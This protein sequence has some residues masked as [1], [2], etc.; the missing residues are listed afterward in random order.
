MRCEAWWP[1]L[2]IPASFWADGK[3]SIVILNCAEYA[4]STAN[5]R[6]LI[7]QYFISNGEYDLKVI[8]GALCA[9][10]TG[11]AALNQSRGTVSTGSKQVRAFP[12][13]GP[14]PGPVRG[15]GP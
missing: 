4:L 5:A 7:L 1:V 11:A 10:G 2:D 3:G 12:E 13:K 8:N 14:L 6:D 9:Y 15:S